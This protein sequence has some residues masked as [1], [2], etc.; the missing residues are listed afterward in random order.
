MLWPKWTYLSWVGGRTLPR[1]PPT[2]PLSKAPVTYQVFHLKLYLISKN[3][4]VAICQSLYITYSLLYLSTRMLY[5]LTLFDP[6][7]F[8]LFWSHP[9]LFLIAFFFFF[10]VL[11]CLFFC[12]FVCFVFAFYLSFW[13]FPNFNLTASEEK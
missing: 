2:S 6:Y 1:S 9:F 11:F 5:I 4:N 7:L 12:F 8:Q 13:I 3:F 10:F